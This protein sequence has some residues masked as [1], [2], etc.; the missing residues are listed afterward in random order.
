VRC[1]SEPLGQS[2]RKQW[3]PAAPVAQREESGIEAAGAP[4][5]IGHRWVPSCARR[6]Q[7]GSIKRRGR[8]DDWPQKIFSRILG[9]ARGAFYLIG[10][11]NSIIM[12]I[13]TRVRRVRVPA[14][15]RNF[16]SDDMVYSSLPLCRSRSSLLGRVA[17]SEDLLDCAKDLF[18]EAKMAAR[19][20]TQRHS[21]RGAGL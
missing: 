21:G 16:T 10:Y 1:R 15:I 11:P 2:S 20:E 12:I 3:S 18:V 8:A 14:T 9:S 6:S 4:P 5:G 7:C 13:V 19:G 17:P